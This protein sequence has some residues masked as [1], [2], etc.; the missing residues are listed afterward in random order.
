MK[1]V[2]GSTLLVGLTAVSYSVL[3]WLEFNR[4]FNEGVFDWAEQAREPR[5]PT[6]Q[7]EDHTYEMWA[8]FDEW[9]ES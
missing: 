6:P 7:T 2:I 9:L 5:Y 8:R 4:L 1:Y 3:A